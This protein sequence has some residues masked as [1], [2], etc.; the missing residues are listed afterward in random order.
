MSKEINRSAGKLLLSALLGLSGLLAGCTPGA[1]LKPEEFA[2]ALE[3]S[4]KSIDT[5]L[6]QGKQ[7][8]AIKQLDDLARGNPERKEP[9]LRKARIQFDAGDYSQ[10]ITSAEEVLQRDSTDRAAK[11][12]R[13]VAGLR[14]AGQSLNELRSDIELK[15]RARADAVTLV[16]IIRDTLGEDVLVPAVEKRREPAPLRKSEPA[17]KRT[18]AA[19]EPRPEAATGG[20]PFDSLK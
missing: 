20:N 1:S 12:I 2:A 15:G 8:E 17:R 9:W 19:A 16:R 5:L 14:V 11:S 6:Q 4:S 18:T 3:Q 7:Q 10:A 13:A